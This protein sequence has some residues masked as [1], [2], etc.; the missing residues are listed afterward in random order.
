MDSNS[1]RTPTGDHEAIRA[2]LRETAKLQKKVQHQ[3]DEMVKENKER[4]KKAGTIDIYLL[5]SLV[6]LGIT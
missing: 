2:D 6:G 4:Q 1:H 3:L 5:E